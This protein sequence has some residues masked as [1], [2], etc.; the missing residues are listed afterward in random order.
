MVGDWW[1]VEPSRPR[2][3]NRPRQLRRDAV[4]RK[5]AGYVEALF[6]ET[7]RKRRP[8]LAE[9]AFPNAESKG[10][11]TGVPAP[12]IRGAPSPISGGLPM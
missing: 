9:T 4:D 7:E 10:E 8:D 6:T 3:L 5:S 2:Q 1:G 12:G 11:G